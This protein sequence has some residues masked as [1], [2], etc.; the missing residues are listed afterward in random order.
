[1]RFSSVLKE[2]GADISRSPI[3]WPVR[4]A[5]SA[6]LA[7]SAAVAASVAV[8][9]GGGGTAATMLD[10]NETGNDGSSGGLDPVASTSNAD[11]LVRSLERLP[12]DPKV[13]RSARS[14]PR[15]QRISRLG[16]SSLTAVLR[17]GGGGSGRATGA[18]GNPL[19][20]TGARGTGVVAN[21]GCAGNGPQTGAPT[22]SSPSI[23]VSM[24]GGLVP[25]LPEASSLPGTTHRTRSSSFIHRSFFGG[26]GGGSSGGALWRAVGSPRSPLQ[27]S[28]VVSAQQPSQSSPS[29]S[30]VNNAL[31]IDSV[32]G[33]QPAGSGSGN[34]AG[35]HGG[36]S[37]SAPGAQIPSWMASALQTHTSPSGSRHGSMAGASDLS[38]L[39][40]AGL[41]LQPAE[42]DPMSRQAAASRARRRRR[43]SVGEI[44]GSMLHLTAQVQ[45]TASP[46]SRGTLLGGASRHD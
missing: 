41:E 32:N 2:I 43:A 34:T 36:G 45:T 15:I 11:G 35:R 37:S 20:G 24:T 17:G 40:A 6:N 13:Q 29:R 7:T 14:E 21:A 5:G 3:Q 1:M 10:P 18:R 46:S 4:R 33:G 42:W 30:I 9:N 16:L 38:V 39:T 25:W 8:G 23:M 28:L 44:L 12:I 22:V 27:A 19:Y 26:G 31:G